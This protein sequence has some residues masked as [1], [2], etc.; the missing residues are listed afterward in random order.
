[1]DNNNPREFGWVE[2]SDSDRDIDIDEVEDRHH[3]IQ[4]R[5]P[6]RRCIAR[7]PV[8]RINPRMTHNYRRFWRNCLIGTLVDCRQFTVRRMQAIVDNC[9]NLRGAVRVVGVSRNNYVFHFNN[10]QDRVFIMDE[11]PWAVQGGLIFFA[12]WEPNMVL[13]N[14]RIAE[15]SVWIQLW[16]IPLEFQTPAVASA[17]GSILGVCLSVDWSPEFPRNLR[18][19]RIRVR[20]PID[21]PL[22]MGFVINT[23]DDQ[24]IWVQCKYERMYR[25]CTGCGRIG[26][27]YPACDW[28]E[29]RINAS[30]HTQMTRINRL[31]GLQIGFVVSRLH[32]VNQARGF[33]NH[34]N[35]R[36]TNV[37]LELRGEEYVYRPM[38]HPPLHF[39]FDP[40]EFF[41]EDGDF[42]NHNGEQ[43]H[44]F[45]PPNGPMADHLFPVEIP[46]VDPEEEDPM[47]WDADDEEGDDV[48]FVPGFIPENPNLPPAGNFAPINA[49]DIDDNTESSLDNNVQYEPLPEVPND[50]PEENAQ[51][52]D[53]RIIISDEEMQSMVEDPDL[54]STALR[55]Y[56]TPPEYVFPLPLIH[57]T[58]EDPTHQAVENED[59]LLCYMDIGIGEGCISNGQLSMDINNYPIFYEN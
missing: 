44:D 40:F 39:D 36:T 32:F 48:G 5:S 26:H 19:M 18:F 56:R 34:A 2:S 38:Q 31:F 7:G 35:R 11:G 24:M 52:V 37:N 30:L 49:L 28:Q 12:P 17:L 50:P 23:D 15:I 58:N 46:A 41:N 47:E 43:E 4:P 27:T 10:I 59:Q 33:I 9:W 8:I 53:S 14:Y 57:F 16:G 55:Y 54:R 21:S 29:Q 3:A 6:P 13:T 25:I 51:P 42:G 45:P 1:M 22:L 20:I